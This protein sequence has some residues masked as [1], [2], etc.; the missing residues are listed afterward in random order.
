[1]CALRHQREQHDEEDETG[2][3]HDKISQ[4]GEVAHR[5]PPRGVWVVQLTR[6]DTAAARSGVT[7]VTLYEIPFILQEWRGSDTVADGQR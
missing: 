7:R 6:V 2:D 4:R 1:M 3:R 5:G